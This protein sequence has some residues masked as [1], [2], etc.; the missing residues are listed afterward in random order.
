MKILKK[1][2]R[3]NRRREQEEEEEEPIFFA[4]GYF[5]L[6]MSYKVIPSGVGSHDLSL[7]QGREAVSNAMCT[8]AFVCERVCIKETLLTQHST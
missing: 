7:L 1:R 4:S 2:K 5:P 8:H 6:F 3:S